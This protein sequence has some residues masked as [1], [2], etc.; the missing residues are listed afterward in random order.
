QVTDGMSDARYPVFDKGGKYLYF[1]AS[2]DVGPS[3]G[4]GMS[5]LNRPVT[6]SVYVTVLSKDDPSPL[7][8][9]S[10]DEKEKKDADKE[11]DKAKKD[12]DKSSVPVKV[13]LEDLDQ[14]TLA[15]PCEARNYY[16]LIAGKAGTLFLL[17]GP[18]TMPDDT[19][20]SGGLP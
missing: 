8:P 12:G 18:T 20:P 4:S 15:L 19:P 11:K 17:E 2:T 5:I 7:A 1:T 16:S 14:R 13:D 9:E 10:D 3:I 6:R